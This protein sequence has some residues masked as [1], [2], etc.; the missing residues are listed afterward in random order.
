MNHVE[1]LTDCGYECVQFFFPPQ[2]CQQ[3]MILIK[4]SVP[5]VKRF[6]HCG[7]DEVEF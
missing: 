6:P 7:S 2:T 1:F 3:S 5:F 4:F